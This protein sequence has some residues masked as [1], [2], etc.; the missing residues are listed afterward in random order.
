[1]SLNDEMAEEAPARVTVIDSRDTSIYLNVAPRPPQS[2]RVAT[3]PASPRVKS[4]TEKSS[5]SASKLQHHKKL[6]TS[7]ETNSRPPNSKEASTSRS[8]SKSHTNSTSTSKR[9]DSRQDF[10][11]HPLPK[12]R[13][14]VPA[15]P[16][17]PCPYMVHVSKKRQADLE[18]NYVDPSKIRYIPG[19]PATTV[20][21]S[22]E[23]D[24]LDLSGYGEFD[25]EGQCFY[26]THH[27]LYG[28]HED[29]DNLVI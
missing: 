12:G 25:K 15:R 1:M 21:L 5:E 20:E 8:A 3:K 29:I 27:Q 2:A 18:Y 26:S 17:P 24:G 16:A 19:V 10:A 11:K 14:R 6:V 23:L 7:R 9:S 22:R 4:P 13:G 28:L